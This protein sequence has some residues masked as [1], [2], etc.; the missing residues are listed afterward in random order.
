MGATYDKGKFDKEKFA[1]LVIYIADRCHAH[2]FFGATKLNKILFFSDFAAFRGFG[3]SITG[4]DYQALEHGPAPVQLLPL[5]HDLEKD[6]S[7]AISRRGRQER[8]VPLRE[9]DLSKLSAHEISIVDAFIEELRDLSAPAVSDLSHD[10]LGWEA[11]IAKGPK[12]HIPY[13]TALV[14]NPEPDAFEAAMLRD[15]GRSYGYAQ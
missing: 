7:I 14:S 13:E 15:T 12:T 8:I 9:P 10:F 1:E 4:A 11:A 5:R 3:T 6:G 2:T